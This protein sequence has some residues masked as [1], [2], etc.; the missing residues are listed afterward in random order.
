MLQKEEVEERVREAQHRPGGRS[1]TEGQRGSPS[2]GS[3]SGG[4]VGG[5]AGSIQ[6]VPPPI[7]KTDVEH[8]EC[9]LLPRAR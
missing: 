2:G 1:K 4:A 5:C 7:R 8:G 6:H 3:F 9:R